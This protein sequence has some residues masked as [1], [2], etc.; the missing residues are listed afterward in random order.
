MGCIET[1]FPG[2][3]LP[4]FD[5]YVNTPKCLELVL[6]GGRCLVTGQAAG[7]AGPGAAGLASFDDLLA[8]FLDQMRYIAQLV[9]KAKADY[10]QILPEFQAAPLQSAL[11]PSCLERGRD[12]YDGGTE[13]HLTGCYLVGLGTTVDSLAAIRQVVFEEHVLTLPDLV[14]ILRADFSG[15]EILRQRL[16]NRAPKFGNDDDRVDGLVPLLVKAFSQAVVTA[17]SPAGWLKLPMIGSVSSHAGMGKRTGATADGRRMGESLSDGGSPAQGRSLKGPTAALR[18][19]AKA[20]H[21]LIPGGEAINL[22]LAPSTLS[23][24]TGLGNLVALLR[25]YTALGGEQLQVNVV[26]RA[27]LEDAVRRPE[28]YRHL[29]VR[30]RR[31]LR[32]LHGA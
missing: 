12:I 28:Q 22:L 16:L 2:R 5:C 20:D 3:S 21:R 31:L 23:R 11:T 26:N 18:S 24:E 7:L 9:L 17:P 19:V 30:V 8:A 14:E 29:I 13:Y 32:V 1:F 25:A 4:W 27:T 10:D 6:T 15:H